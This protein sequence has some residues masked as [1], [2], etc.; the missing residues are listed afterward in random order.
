MHEFIFWKVERKA[1]LFLVN[2]R[3]APVFVRRN[4]W[5]KPV[6]ANWMFRIVGEC[7]PAPLDERRTIGDTRC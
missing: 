5:W 1:P 7:G 4:K 6:L 2:S 3:T